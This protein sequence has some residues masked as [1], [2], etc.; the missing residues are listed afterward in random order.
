MKFNIRTCIPSPS[1][2]TF[3]SFSQDMH[4]AAEEINIKHIFF[5]DKDFAYITV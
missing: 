4:V 3:L 5:F 1:A 2:I